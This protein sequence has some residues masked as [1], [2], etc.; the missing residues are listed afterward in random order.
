MADRK[1]GNEKGGNTKQIAASIRKPVLSSANKLEQAL[2]FAEKAVSPVSAAKPIVASVPLAI[3]GEAASLPQ[4]G[5]V[6]D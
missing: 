3:S 4:T 6:P 1:K 5:R 2:A